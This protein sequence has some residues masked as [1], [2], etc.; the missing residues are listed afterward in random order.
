MSSQPQSSENVN[1]KALA[2]ASRPKGVEKK[3][4]KPSAIYVAKKHAEALLRATV[5]QIRKTKALTVDEIDRAFNA[6][7]DYARAIDAKAEADKK[8]AEN[9]LAKAEKKAAREAKAAAAAAAQAAAPEGVT[10]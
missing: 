5:A 8:R 6:T 4:R 2:E 9:K 7:G 1:E 3:A 10:A